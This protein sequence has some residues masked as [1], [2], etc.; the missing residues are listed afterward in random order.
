MAD[1]DFW[2]DPGKFISDDCLKNLP[3]TCVITAEF[4]YTSRGARKFAERLKSNAPDKFLGMLDMPGVPHGYEAH[5]KQPECKL[6]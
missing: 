5:Y 6:F 4:D 3:P 2:V 1:Q